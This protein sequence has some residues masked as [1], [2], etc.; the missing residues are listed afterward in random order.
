MLISE[1]TPISCGPDVSGGASRGDSRR[2]AR[3]WVGFVPVLAA[4]YV[5]SSA[6]VR[7]GGLFN[8]PGVIS[9]SAGNITTPGGTEHGIS[10]NWEVDGGGNTIDVSSINPGDITVAGP[11]GTLTVTR[12]TCGGGRSGRPIEKGS[13][14][15]PT[16]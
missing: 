12:S 16:R 6:D 1:D 9:A 5:A 14:P 10:V 8:P 7:A 11:A 2:A 15:T 3:R 13:F 4:I